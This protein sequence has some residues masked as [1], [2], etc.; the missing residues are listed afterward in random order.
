MLSHP[1]DEPAPDMSDSD[2]GPEVDGAD[3]TCLTLSTTSQSTLFSQRSQMPR[4]PSDEPASDTVLADSCFEL[5]HPGLLRGAPYG[6]VLKCGG[7]RLVR[8]NRKAQ[9]YH[10]SEQVGTLAAFISHN[11]DVQR[12]PKFLALAIHYNGTVSL[13]LTLVLMIGIV[14]SD[15]AGLLPHWSKTVGDE[16]RQVGPWNVLLSTPIYWAIVSGKHDFARLLGLKGS[17]VFFDSMCINQEEDHSEEILTRRAGINAIPAIVSKSKA[18]VVVLTPLYLQKLWT[19]FELMCFMAH[20]DG[21]NHIHF[22][23][24]VLAKTA[25]W[26]SVYMYIAVVLGVF[27]Q[28]FGNAISMPK[29]LFTIA[30]A[31]IAILGVALLMAILRSWGLELKA[32]IEHAE[33]F[34]LNSALCAVE[35]DRGLLREVAACLPKY[36]LDSRCPSP[37]ESASSSISAKFSAPVANDE[38]TSDVKA[39]LNSC[40]GR[41]GVPFRYLVGILMPQIALI[42]DGQA[43]FVRAWL[44]ADISSAFLA[45]TMV[46]ALTNFCTMLA[47]LTLVCYLQVHYGRK[48]RLRATCISMVACVMYVLLPRSQS[49]LY[50]SQ[51]AQ[52][53]TTAAMLFLSL[54]SCWFCWFMHCRVSAKLCYF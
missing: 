18:M 22:E 42:C 52:A 44:H 12:F 21:T 23:P 35:S 31:L 16:R 27:Y 36:F 34:D 30:I 15:I 6:E 38:L 37:Q 28:Y 47:I 5:A 40:F 50:N 11:W 46:R 4:Q 1:I 8:S 49:F 29:F 48:A 14:V 7:R 26:G 10:V 39:A 53:A 13:L 51:P 20:K 45:F 19:T 54:A 25:F 41:C 43:G 24:A 9:N 17:Y 3:C 33:S 32:I 2:G